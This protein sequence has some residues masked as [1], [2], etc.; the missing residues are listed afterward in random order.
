MNQSEFE[1]N[2]C[3]RRQAQKNA[4]EHVTVGFGFT[5]DWLRFLLLLRYRLLGIHIFKTTT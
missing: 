4:C 1:V 2:T 5:S 3:N